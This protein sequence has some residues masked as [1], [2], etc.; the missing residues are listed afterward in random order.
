[1]I[2]KRTCVRCNCELD[3]FG[4]YKDAVVF[5]DELLE[6]GTEVEY[7]DELCDGCANELV[8]YSCS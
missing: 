6:D 2:K 3:I 7:G 4:S 1:M 8:E 5:E